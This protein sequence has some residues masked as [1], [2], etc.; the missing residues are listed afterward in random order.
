MLTIA[1]IFNLPRSGR[2][3]SSEE[4]GEGEETTTGDTYRG[5]H[6]AA[7]GYPADPGTPPP[8][9]LVA[10]ISQVRRLIPSIGPGPL[11]TGC[12]SRYFYSQSCVEIL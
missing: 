9:H 8:R 6:A 7:G 5:R 10:Q 11:H 1:L 2:N 3:T 12:R 4:G